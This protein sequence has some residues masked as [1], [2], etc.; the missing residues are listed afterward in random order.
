MQKGMQ[1]RYPKEGDMQK[2]M[3]KNELCKKMRYAKKGMQKDERYA[4]N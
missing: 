2:G 3:Q 4:K 1:K